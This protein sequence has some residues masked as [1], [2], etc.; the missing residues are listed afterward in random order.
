MIGSTITTTLPDDAD[1]VWLQGEVA[2]ALDRPALAVTAVEATPLAHRI[3]APTTAGLDRVVLRT[4]D[5][6]DVRLVVKRLQAA[7]HGLPAVIPPDVRAHLDA[8]IPWRL[9]ADALTSG[10]AA[11]L[12]P[13]L[14]LATVVAV[15]E[16]PED[17]LTLWCCDV[18]PVDSGWASDDIVRAAGLLGRLAARRQGER[19]LGP[20]FLV[21]YR[22]NQLATWAVPRLLADET[23]RHPVFVGA[24]VAALRGRLV[25]LAG[26]LDEL[27]TRVDSVPRLPAHG[28]ATPM[29]LLR[30]AADPTTFV[31]VDWGT[32]TH[33]PAGFDLVPLL[34][35]RAE[36][37][38]QAADEVPALLGPAV[39]AYR[40]GLADEGVA[41]DP[42][43]LRD[44]V[45][46]TALLRYPLTSLPLAA[47]DGVPVDEATAPAKAAFVAMVL[48]LE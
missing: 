13:G 16:R 24:Q 11:A 31:L 3:S 39:A 26:R 17:R 47:L 46:A 23:W 41:L 30:P 19:P 38:D 45:V 6:P 33:G 43:L 27:Q 28:D 40:Q 14:S 12:P 1:L 5:G 9:E 44:A 37:G 18:D 29:N 25:D 21:T 34:F 32:A 7:R 15:V 10:L 36:C 4:A 8:L 48:D 35:G 2:R 42:V 22:A 20:D